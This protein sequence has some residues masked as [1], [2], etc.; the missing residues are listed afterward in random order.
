MNLNMHMA[1]EYFVQSYQFFEQICCAYFSEELHSHG[2]GFTPYSEH[3][4][5]FLAT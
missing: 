5:F 1:N 4:Y 2:I 3:S